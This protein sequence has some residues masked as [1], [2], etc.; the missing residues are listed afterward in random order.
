MIE[1]AEVC[2]KDISVSWRVLNID[3]ARCGTLSFTII[4]NSNFSMIIENATSGSLTIPDLSVTNYYNI[5]IY[6]CNDAGPGKN[7]S[8]MVDGSKLDIVICNYVVK[9][10]NYHV[11]VCVLHL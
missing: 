1:S 10:I 8:M 2:V 4:V 5:D 9:N 7:D 6:G 3:S 11:Y